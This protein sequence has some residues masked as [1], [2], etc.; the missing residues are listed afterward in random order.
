M[1]KK[2]LQESLPAF[3]H[4]ACALSDADADADAADAAE[5]SMMRTAVGSRMRLVSLAYS[6]VDAAVLQVTATVL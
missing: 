5:K 2:F 3:R 6:T 1:R 4:L